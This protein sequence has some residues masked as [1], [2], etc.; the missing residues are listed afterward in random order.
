MAD[1]GNGSDGQSI[2][3]SVPIGAVAA[4]ALVALAVASYLLTNRS[5]EGTAGAA[6][7]VARSGRRAGRRLGL[8]TLIALLENDATRKVVLALLK[9]MARRV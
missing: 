9:A 6:G 4:G 8:N 1:R 3:V 7:Q 2:G 5:E